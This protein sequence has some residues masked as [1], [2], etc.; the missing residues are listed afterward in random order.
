MRSGVTTT[1]PLIERGA[2]MFQDISSMWW[3]LLL[4]GI[5]SIL[6]GIVAIVNPGLTALTLVLFFGAYA[7]V[8]G[9]FAI[10]MA[11]FGAKQVHNRLI[12]GLEGILGI[13]FGLLVLTWPGISV[14]VFLQ[15]IA[16]WALVTGVVQII[17]AFPER[18]IWM[19]LAGL[20]SIIFGIVFFRFPGEGVIAL[21]TVIGLYAIVFGVLFVILSFRLRGANST[22]KIRPR[23]QQ[24][25]T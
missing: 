8:D 14:I 13:I 23:N 7:V 9:G 18:N 1:I 20:V 22:I 19:G 2:A 15:V 5:L 17:S 25:A 10:G 16:I 6:F 4:R 3:L 12:L 11:I 21:L 24:R